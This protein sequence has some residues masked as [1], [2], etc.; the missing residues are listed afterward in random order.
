MDMECAAGKTG[1]G[2]YTPGL[3]RSWKAARCVPGW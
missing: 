3:K 1:D 2:P